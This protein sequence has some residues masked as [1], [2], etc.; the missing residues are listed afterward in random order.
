MSAKSNIPLINDIEDNH[1]S[2]GSGPP[3]IIV[4]TLDVEVPILQP[5]LMKCMS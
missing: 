3:G 2:N 5:G 4:S 1:G